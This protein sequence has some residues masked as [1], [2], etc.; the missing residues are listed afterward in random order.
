MTNAPENKEKRNI[1][2]FFRFKSRF[3]VSRY[4]YFQF[5]LLPLSIVYE[6]FRPLTTIFRSPT[7]EDSDTSSQATTERR[8][9]FNSDI[10][11]MG[12]DLPKSTLEEL[13]Q[14]HINSDDLPK[15]ELKELV[16]QLKNSDSTYYKKH[17]LPMVDINKTI[18]VTTEGMVAATKL[19]LNDIPDP[20][21]FGLQ[22]L[23]KI[24]PYVFSVNPDYVFPVNPYESKYNQAIEEK[25]EEQIKALLVE[26]FKEGVNTDAIKSK[27]ME[28]NSSSPP[29]IQL[30]IMQGMVGKGENVVSE[31]GKQEAID[32]MTRILLQKPELLSETALNFHEVLGGYAVAYSQTHLDKPDEPGKEQP[33][34][35][36]M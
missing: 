6:V 9:S 10:D 17:I 4:G 28:Y 16:E 3:N 20:G 35:P 24:L 19:R 7:K 5:L 36:S 32:H 8:S 21:S 18:S 2:D 1:D 34:R 25:D 31:A 30:A 29:D 23:N 22:S 13:V 33:E 14:Q 15:S 12:N 27:I 11:H 26:D